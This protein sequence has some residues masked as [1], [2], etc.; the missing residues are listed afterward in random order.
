MDKEHKISIIFFVLAMIVAV[1][2]ITYL[3]YMFAFLLS[4]R[5]AVCAGQVIDKEVKAPYVTSPMVI[6]SGKIPITIP[7]RYVPETY[8]FTVCDRDECSSN[9]VDKDLFDS[10][11][12]NDPINLCYK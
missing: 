11:K 2:G 1:V 12:L 10:T 3:Q 7:G 9:R 6:M 5:E 4:K 8:Y